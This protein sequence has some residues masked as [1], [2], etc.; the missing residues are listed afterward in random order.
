MASPN[1]MLFHGYIKRAYSQVI[2][3]TMDEVRLERSWLPSVRIYDTESIHGM[4]LHVL[5]LNKWIHVTCNSGYFWDV[6]RV[7]GYIYMFTSTGIPIIMIRQSHDCHVH[8]GNPYTGK[9]SL[10]TESTLSVTCPR[11]HYSYNK[12]NLPERSLQLSLCNQQDISDNSWWE[13]LSVLA[14]IVTVAGLR[15]R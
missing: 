10:L 11:D 7:I 12:G 15:F 6:A 5:N 4:S 8:H 13:Y 2:A 14:N 9:Q 1:R 3:D